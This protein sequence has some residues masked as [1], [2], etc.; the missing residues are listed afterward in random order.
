[1]NQAH[2]KKIYIASVF[3]FCAGVERAVEILDRVIKKH[4][5]PVY[6]RHAIIH[7]RRVLKEFEKKG[8]VFVE[9]VNKIPNQSVVVL[10]AHGSSLNI[11]QT[12]KKKKFILYDAMCP[13]V[14]KV[15]LE[16]KKF[17]KDEHF[18]FYLGHKNHPEAEGVIGDVP[19]KSIK[20][21]QSENDITNEFNYLKNKKVAVLTQTTLSFDDTKRVIK[22]LKGKFPNLILPPAFD[23]CFATQNRQNSVKKLVDKVKTIIVVGSSTSS[24]SNRLREIAEKYGARAYLIDDIFQIN[25]N[26]F[27]NVYE[28]GITAGASAP[29]NLIDEVISYLKNKSTEIIKLKDY[30]ENI[31]FPIPFNI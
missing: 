14:L 30:K 3:G 13:L 18:I 15:H 1:M 7:N 28:I 9:D 31:H 25:K 10:S 27:K 29:K 8:V 12:A 19:K 20:L 2:I 23:I 4:G 6:S 11:Y 17:I 24:N 26:W 21:I 16:A 22:K 5:P